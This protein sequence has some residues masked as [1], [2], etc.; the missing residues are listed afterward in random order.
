MLLAIPAGSCRRGARAPPPACRVR[1]D[2]PTSPTSQPFGEALA[3]AK[4]M[5]TRRAAGAC[6]PT[7]ARHRRPIPDR[8]RLVVDARRA[9]ERWWTRTTA[10]TCSKATSRCSARTGSSTS[11]GISDT[12]RRAAPLADAGAAAPPAIAGQQ[13][14]RS[15]TASSWSSSQN[16]IARSR[17]LSRATRS[18]SRPTTSSA[19]CRCS[20]STT[21]TSTRTACVNVDPARRD[22]RARD[23]HVGVQAA[24][25]RQAPAQRLGPLR[26]R[27]R[28]R[29][30]PA[31]HRRLPR[32]PVPG[33]P[34]GVRLFGTRDNNRCSTTWLVP[35]PRE[36]HQ[37]RAERRQ[38]SDAAR[39]RR[40]RRQRLPPGL[41][42]LGLHARRSRSSTT[43]TARATSSTSTT[44]ASSSGPPRSAAQRRATTTSPISATTATATS[45]A[46]TSRRRCTRARRRRTAARSS[47][48]TADIRAG[49]AAAE[50]SRDFDWCARGCRCSTRSGDEDPFD[51]KAERLRRDLREPAVRRR[52]HQ[53]LDPPADAADRRRG[54]GAV[55]RNGVLQRAAL[56]EGTGPVELRESRPDP[57]RAS[58]PTST[59]T[60]KLRLSA[61]STTSFRGHRGARVARNQGRIDE[62]HRLDVSVA[63]TWRPLLIQNVVLRASAR[64]WLPGK[65]LK[66][67]LGD[68]NA[69]YFVLGNCADVLTA[70]MTMQIDRA[71]MRSS[72]AAA[73]LVLRLLPC[74]AGGIRGRRARRARATSRRRPSP[75][76]QT[77]AEADAK[78]AGCMTLPHRDRPPTMH[79]NPAVVLG[80]TD[81]HGGDAQVTWP[82]RPATRLAGRVRRSARRRRT[83]CRAY[84]QS[85]ELARRA[86]IPSAATRCSTASRRSSSASSTR[87]TTASRAR[88]AA[89]AT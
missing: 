39:R 58:A 51:D 46:G 73:S 21:S 13:R 37:Q 17:A 62:R 18:S 72:A 38:P 3:A 64:R 81:C 15:A 4:R 6:T 77:A 35:A 14:H 26:L 52:R 55:G 42:V 5:S 2:Q 60:P 89:P 61:T 67:A 8:W 10:T 41:A 82:R 54:R 65:G 11:V 50:L 1:D 86:P 32:L 66:A 68:E 23:S 40:L 28:P 45:A 25:R 69:A 20:T 36:G 74:I 44:T 88:P 33:Q 29:R 63:L 7:A 85:V 27:Q 16:F 78:S 49:F 47:S 57:A 48:E 56:V 53:L 87:A 84:P 19:S 34:L 71:V 22:A 30:H 24:V 9:K 76:S 43:A 79:A 31:V 59:C 12:R 70:G 80:C 75:S 83:C